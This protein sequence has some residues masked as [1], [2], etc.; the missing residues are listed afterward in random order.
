LAGAAFFGAAALGAA[1]GLA[2]TAFVVTAF[3]GVVAAFEP[4]TFGLGMGL[5]SLKL[6]IGAYR[7]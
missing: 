3:F 5:V 2:A 4:V 6:I 1:A 7:I